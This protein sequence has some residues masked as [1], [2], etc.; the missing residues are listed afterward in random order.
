MEDIN[1]LEVERDIKK[2]KRNKSAEMDTHPKVVSLNE[3]VTEYPV[4]DSGD[5]LQ[6][7]MIFGGKRNSLSSCN[8]KKQDGEPSVDQTIHSVDLASRRLGQTCKEHDK[9]TFRREIRECDITLY[10]SPALMNCEPAVCGARVQVTLSYSLASTQAGGQFNPGEFNSGHSIDTWVTIGVVNLKH[11]DEKIKKHSK[12]RDVQIHYSRNYP[13]RFKVLANLYR[14][15][16]YHIE[17]EAITI[18]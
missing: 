11:L 10:I 6:S 7:W 18:T 4:K 17:K 1:W 2:M 3:G 16:S 12:Q 9:N 15:F 14:R 13:V 8:T 5:S